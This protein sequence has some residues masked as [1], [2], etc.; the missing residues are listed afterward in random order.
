LHWQTSFDDYYLSNLEPGRK[1]NDLL[2]AKG[3]RL[4]FGN[5]GK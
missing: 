3:R 5:A 1:T 4:T 2:L